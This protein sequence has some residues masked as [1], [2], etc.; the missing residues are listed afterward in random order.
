[1]YSSIV[2]LMLAVDDVIAP[3]SEPLGDPDVLVE[4]LELAKRAFKMT[5]AS[6]KHRWIL[7]EGFPSTAVAEVCADT[8]AI[9]S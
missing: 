8:V 9:L 3:A 2:M 4:P 5:H 1:M 7:P 6:V